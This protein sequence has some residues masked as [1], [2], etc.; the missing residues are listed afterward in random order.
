MGTTSTSVPEC[1]KKTPDRLVVCT[2]ER[3]V[4]HRLL[5]TG[6]GEPSTTGTTTTGSTRGRSRITWTG[7]PE[8]QGP[9]RGAGDNHQHSIGTTG[10]AS[11]TGP[12]RSTG[13]STGGGRQHHVK[14]EGGEQPGIIH[15]NIHSIPYPT[16]PIH[17]SIHAYV[18]RP[19][20]SPLHLRVYCNI[21]M[22]M[23]VEKGTRAHTHPHKCTSTHSP[24][25][26]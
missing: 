7:P 25:P 4:T 15:A 22:N 23:Y 16:L 1:R 11:T 9:Q 12:Q 3:T 8:P 19:Y 24:T 13:R 20:N 5:H 21:Y 6:V 10:G 14:G 26:F 2:V 18:T 17:A